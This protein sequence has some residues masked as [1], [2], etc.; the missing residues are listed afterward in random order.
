MRKFIVF[1]LL[2]AAGLFL[3]LQLDKREKGNATS[4]SNVAQSTG[5]ASAENP[6]QSEAATEEASSN[7]SSATVNGPEVSNKPQIENLDGWTPTYR[8]PAEVESL[9]GERVVGIFKA[10]STDSYNSETGTKEY[11]FK[12][13]HAEPVGDPND[14][15]YLMIGVHVQFFD[16][17]TGE[18]TMALRAE[19]ARGQLRVGD[20]GGVQNIGGT[21]DLEMRN[22]VV[23]VKTGHSLAPF[24]LVAPNMR[25]G[26]DLNRF[27]AEGE[28]PVAL[29]GKGLSAKGWNLT[30][31]R[32]SGQVDFLGGGKFEFQGE[33]EDKMRF[34]TEKGTPL[35]L[36]HTARE[37]FEKFQLRVIGG[38]VLE[39]E[40]AN[41]W[42]VESRGLALQ[43][44]R[45]A[46]GDY[47]LDRLDTSGTVRALRGDNLFSGS[48]VRLVQQ[49][50]GELLD[51]HIANNPKA[52]IAFKGEDGVSSMVEIRGSGPMV[53][54][55]ENTAGESEQAEV[56]LRGGGSILFP[57]ET[58][59]IQ[60]TFRESLALWVDR[61]HQSGTFE[62]R[63]RVFIGQGEAW[64]RTDALDSIVWSAL[65]NVVDVACEG[66]TTARLYDEEHGTLD[67]EAEQGALLQIQGEEWMFPQASGVHT[68]R[69][70][71]TPIEIRAHELRDLNW[72][73]QTFRAW[74]SVVLQ[75]PLGSVQCERI[76]AQENGTLTLFGSHDRPAQLELLSGVVL[77]KDLISGTLTAVELE[78]AGDQVTCTGQVETDLLTRQ[79]RLRHKSERFTLNLTREDKAIAGFRIFSG[80]LTRFDWQVED[81][82]QMLLACQN[83]HL[84]AQSLSES[85]VGAKD[86]ATGS[87]SFSLRAEDV[88]NLSW[89][90]EG[91]SMSL[92]T[93]TLALDGQVQMV[94]G[95][96]KAELYE[97]HADGGFSYSESGDRRFEASGKS[98]D[99]NAQGSTYEVQPHEGGV[100]VATGLLPQMALPFRIT[101]SD[102]RLSE[103]TLVANEPELRV[104]LS[105]LPVG[106]EGDKPA[107]ASFFR[108][109]K[110]EVTPNSIE[111]SEGVFVSGTDLSGVPVSL[112]TQIL[113][114]SGNLRAVVKGET[115]LQAMDDLRATGGF[116]FV[117]GNLAR[118]RGEKLVV[119]PTS[120]L[121]AGTAM[122]RVRVD[123]DDLYLETE[124]LVA[125]LDNFLVTTDRG[126]IRGGQAKGEWSLEYASLQPIQRNGETMFAM[127][128]PTYSQGSRTARSNWAMVWINLEAWRQRGRAALW[129]DAP[130]EQEQWVP[131]EVPNAARPDLIQDFLASL[132]NEQL[133]HYL[134]AML[135]EGDVEASVEDRRV[136]RADSLYADVAGCQAQLD[137]AEITRV[138]RLNGQD[139]KLRIRT[140]RL[141]A[142]AEGSLRA[143]KATITTCDHE[144]PHYVV[145]VGELTLLPRA[146]QRWKFSAEGNRIAFQNGM[147]MPMPSISNVILDSQGG[148][149]GF[150]NEQ[151]EV[152]TVENIALQNTPRFGTILGTSLAY[153]I[154]S[155]GKVVAS[156]LQFDSDKVRGRWRVEGSWLSSR[157]P[158]LGVGLQL[159][160]RDREN[161]TR[162]DFWLDIYARGI[163]DDGKDRGLIRVPDNETSSVRHW[164]NVRGR[165]PFDDRQWIDVVFNQQGDAGVQSEFFQKDYQR[166]EERESYVHW[167]KARDGHFFSGRIQVQ[168]DDFRTE[169]ERKPSLGAY[170]GLSELFKL[171]SV[172]V[173]YRASIDVESL[174]RKEGDLRFERA[175]LDSNGVPDGL[176]DRSTLRA[177]STHRIEVPIPTGI[178]GTSVTPFV[179]ARFTA[180]DEGVNAAD[181]PSRA[182]VFGGL[183]LQ[184]IFTRAAGMAYHTLIPRIE[185]AQE[186]THDI[187]GGVPVTFDAVEAAQDGDRVEVGLRSLW[188]RPDQEHW[189]DFDA[190]ISQ[191]MNREGGLPDTEELRFLGGARTRFGDVPVGL[192]QDYRQDLDTGSTLY[193]RTIVAIQPTESLLMQLGHQHAWE[194]LAG[195]LFETASLDMRYRINPKWEFGVT[196]YTNIQDGGNL[197]SEFTLRRF[198]HDFV[199]ELEVTRYA[200]EGGT[201][202]GLNFMPLLAWKPSSLGIL[203]R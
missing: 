71:K 156:L 152:T 160:E 19:K 153:D 77:A 64:L 55:A 50:N 179:N 140:D 122:K 58:K 79:G 22:V 102:L 24:Q 52:E 176:G 103:T 27:V 13:D 165:Y 78:L 172:P 127:A 201:G 175:F 180:W 72:A 82:E 157:G 11:S 164:I 130:A 65:Q 161:A 8:N 166:F 97:L 158:L 7:Q 111:F 36:T 80:G 46:S 10:F 28:D 3:L 81:K 162:E 187:S 67:F 56:E 167:R 112:R 39:M 148:F 43:A 174:S 135:L 146:D 118:A 85:L 83:L 107:E 33:G 185:V 119:L 182:V 17:V 193:S 66:K 96:R 134:R 200:G 189:L 202:I 143:K 171:G 51:L 188:S 121:L 104:G 115:E 59:P 16:P 163:P 120:I 54:H 198:S 129:G 18:G 45:A 192:E 106:A 1:A 21:S 93:S 62:A 170:R 159:R 124:R 68:T 6:G 49:E 131:S 169:V 109:G 14:L 12:C 195:G 60:V 136:I 42:R 197:A 203:D 47:T 9:T 110:L 74:G 128:S 123:L 89:K 183:R 114:L 184:G 137:Q 116:D 23:D 132:A 125:D 30:L 142:A 145:E 4:P 139:H 181:D 168:Q 35:H 133:P 70:G 20:G 2:F 61:I 154:G 41:E 177:D 25:A 101:A 15:L 191:R 92:T 76:Q 40:G 138:L 190:S 88:S 186:L 178:P 38:G 57:N 26:V 5:T 87:S 108:A 113:S 31:D 126:V 150:E 95:Q 149:E 147:G 173:N 53:V 63:G 117:Y 69:A 99:Y 32:A 199:L 155:V 144:E 86:Q 141:V 105:I 37:G 75:N 91:S 194:P 84:T 98:L 73:T 34:F 90:S 44:S 29:T 100:I 48:G 94:D 196:N 151:G